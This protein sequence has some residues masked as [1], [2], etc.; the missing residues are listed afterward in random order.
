MKKQLGHFGMGL[1]LAVLA[2]CSSPSTKL[3]NEYL[4]GATLW[5]QTAGE[6]RALLH[7]SYRLARALLDADLK[8]KRKKGELP[9]A[10]VVDVDETVLDNSPFEGRVVVTD[11]AYPKGWE[12]WIKLAKAK[13]LAGSLDFL[14]YAHSK[15]VRIFY[16]TNRKEAQKADTSKN[17]KEVGFPDVSDETLLCRTADSNKEPRRLHIRSKHRIVM[18][19]GDNLNDLDKVFDQ[20][21]VADRMNAV[22]GAKDKFGTEYIMIPNP[23]YGDWEGALYQFNF[24]K[25]DEEKF[26]LRR[27]ALTSF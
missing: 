15:G 27:E 22:E 12:E 7:Q 19:I 3:Q 21:T 1:M 17:L 24:T 5:F 4:T 26:R 9:P 13:P 10:V 16:V 11:E 6:A 20:K 2:G 25:S 18:L 8:V 14:N 23:M